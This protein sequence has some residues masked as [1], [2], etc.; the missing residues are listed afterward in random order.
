M[1]LSGP[2]QF[3]VRGLLFAASVSLLVV[4]LLKLLMFGL[5]LVGHMHL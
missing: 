2:I 4:G 1:N 3:L 5:I